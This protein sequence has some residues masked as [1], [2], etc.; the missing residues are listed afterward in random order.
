QYG[1]GSRVPILKLREAD[2]P[3]LR[4]LADY[5]YERVFKGYTEKQWGMPPEQLSSSVTARVPVSISRDDRY[6]HDRFQAIPVEGYTA[7]F[8][9]ILEHPNIQVVLNTDYRAVIDQLQFNRMV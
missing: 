5:V 4:F 2:D 8:Q 9:R 3:D 6:F 7:M 1:F